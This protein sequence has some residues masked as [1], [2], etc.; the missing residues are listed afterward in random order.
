MATY[1]VPKGTM[2]RTTL[3]QFDARS[4]LSTKDHEDS[5]RRFRVWVCANS[6]SISAE[7][8]GTYRA[9]GWQSIVM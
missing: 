6:R 7:V 9:M 4:Y 5:K 8:S 2:P 1:R 3:R